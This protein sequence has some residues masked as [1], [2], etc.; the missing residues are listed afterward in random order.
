MSPRCDIFYVFFQLF[1]EL[2][3]EK[4]RKDSVR[5]LTV[6]AN[7]ASNYDCSNLSSFRDMT[8]SVIFSKISENLNLKLGAS[9]YC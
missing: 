9:E 5:L 8:F 3:Y 6:V 2:Q 7:F 1:K 4:I